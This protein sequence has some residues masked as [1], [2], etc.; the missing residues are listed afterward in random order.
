MG[1]R[2]EPCGTPEDSAI[3]SDLTPFKTTAWERESKKS[4][5]QLNVLPRFVID[6]YNDRW[7]LWW[8][9]VFLVITEVGK[10][11]QHIDICLKLWTQKDE[12]YCVNSCENLWHRRHVIK[13]L[14]WHN[15]VYLDRVPNKYWQFHNHENSV[16]KAI[17][18]TGVLKWRNTSIFAN[19][20]LHNL[21]SYALVWEI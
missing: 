6:D 19:C 13:Q 21:Y 3:L 5:T 7:W 2:T 14:Q 8:W 12:F 1:P 17:Q 4:L 18:I 20:S 9:M 16:Q 15:P 11:N 10:S